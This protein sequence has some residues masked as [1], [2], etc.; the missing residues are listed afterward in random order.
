MTG[1][2]DS[3]WVIK[4][5]LVYLWYAIWCI[6]GIGLLMRKC[7]KMMLGFEFFTQIL[8]GS[9]RNAIKRLVFMYCEAMSIFFGFE[10]VL[11]LVYFWLSIFWGLKCLKFSI[12]WVFQKYTV[13]DPSITYQ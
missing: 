13:S 1:G 12:F 7:D 8:Q 11:N 6:I 4:R 10:I 3:F 9:C 2:S 5:C